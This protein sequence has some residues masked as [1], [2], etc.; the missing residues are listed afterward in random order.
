MPEDMPDRVLEDMSDRMPEDMPDRMP[1]GMPE[2][3][4]EGMPERMLDKMSDRMPE[5]M[6]DR[7]PEDVPDKMS[8][9]EY[10]K[11]C[12]RECQIKCQIECQK[13]C[14][15]ESQKM[16]QIKCQ[17]ICQIECQIECQKI[18]H[19]DWQ[20]VCQKICMIECPKEVCQSNGLDHMDK[21]WQMISQIEYKIMCVEFEWFA[22]FALSWVKQDQA[23][24]FLVTLSYFGC[25][26]D[27]CWRLGTVDACSAYALP[28]CFFCGRLSAFAQLRQWCRLVPWRLL[29][30][31]CESKKHGD[32]LVL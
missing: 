14:Q 32:L 31:T 10:Q 18:C 27:P 12:Q 23:K 13:I 24:G 28:A 20:K 1:E 2:R 21:E 5:D 8:E 4:P 9:V 16:C 19:I 15:I 29:G 25:A 17:K 3:M 30:N 22:C 26:L 7:M 6:P 11:V